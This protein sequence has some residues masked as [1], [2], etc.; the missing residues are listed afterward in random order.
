MDH[1][2]PGEPHQG[3]G[4]AAVEAG[5]ALLAHDLAPAVP[6]AA[7]GAHGAHRQPRPHQLQRIDGKLHSA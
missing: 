1:L 4:E 5:P 6:D 3:G 7:V 2:V